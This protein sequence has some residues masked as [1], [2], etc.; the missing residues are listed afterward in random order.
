[1][2]PD[3]LIYNFF[4]RRLDERIKAYGEERMRR[5]VQKLKDLTKQTVAS[6]NF[7]PDTT[8]KGVH[9]SDKVGVKLSCNFRS[10]QVGYMLRVR[11]L[12]NMNDMERNIRSGL[13]CR[14]E[15]VFL[16]FFRFTL[17]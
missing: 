13:K 11:T 3:Y 17:N 9:N 8:R 14:F 15:T 10:R 12:Y 1:M 5:D 4:E 6:C 7:V 16:F 2:K